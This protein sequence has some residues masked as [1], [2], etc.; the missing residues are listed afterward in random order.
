MQELVRLFQLAARMS[1]VVCLVGLP[2]SAACT[3]PYNPLQDFEPVSP[4]TEL[5]VPKASAPRAANYPIEQV[6]R[7]KYMVKLLG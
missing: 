4:A 6:T 5:E 1:G 7:G 3:T 2:F